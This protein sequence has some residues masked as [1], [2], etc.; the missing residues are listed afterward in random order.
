[1]VKC[2][3]QGIKF[4]VDASSLQAFF[5]LSL[6]LEKFIGLVVCMSLLFFLSILLVQFHD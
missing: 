6:V 2:P 4:S 1:M 5:F 3:R